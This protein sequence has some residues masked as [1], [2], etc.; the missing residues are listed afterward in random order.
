MWKPMPPAAYG[1][2]GD[3]FDDDRYDDEMQAWEAQRH[4]SN[5]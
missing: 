5:G 2:G 1:C 3:P 4:Q